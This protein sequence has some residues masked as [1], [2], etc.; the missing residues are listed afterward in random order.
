MP[1]PRVLGAP[2]QAQFPHPARG[3]CFQLEQYPLGF[4]VG[5]YHDMNVLQAHLDRAEV[6]PRAW[7]WPRMASRTAARRGASSANGGR[8]NDAL[9]ADSSAGDGDVIVP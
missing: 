7:Q 6:P 2:H 4:R 8:F 3:P 9:T 5:L 1:A